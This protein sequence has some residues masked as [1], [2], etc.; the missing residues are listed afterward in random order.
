MRATK[1]DTQLSEKVIERYR[2][3]PWG[4]EVEFLKPFLQPPRGEIRVMTL[5]DN[6]ENQTTLWPTENSLH[7]DEVH[8]KFEESTLET[9]SSEE[10][11]WQDQTTISSDNRK[12]KAIE[13]IN[14]QT[15]SVNQ[16]PNYSEKRDYDDNFT[17]DDIDLIFLGYAKTIKKFPPR[18]QSILKFKFARLIMEEE[19]K[20]DTDND[21]IRLLR[22]SK[23]IPDVSNVILIE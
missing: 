10:Y 9:Q 22:E 17:Y 1:E 15:I 5:Q 3:W 12:R 16:I 19:L 13:E 20:D 2:S 18:R 11:N 7:S 6:S 23:T 14:L 4:K 8:L 21:D